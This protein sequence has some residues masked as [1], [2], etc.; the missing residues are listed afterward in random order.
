[1]FSTTKVVSLFI[2]SM[3]MVSTGVVAGPTPVAAEINATTIS[4]VATKT[5]AQASTPTQMR[6]VE[7]APKDNSTAAH[8][9]SVATKMGPAM[10]MAVL[11]S[12]TFALKEPSRGALATDHDRDQSVLWM[13][14]TGN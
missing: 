7:S 2:V 13:G 11:V 12:T 1:M 3:M 14:Y 10:T 8:A 6:S 9:T 4:A 5:A